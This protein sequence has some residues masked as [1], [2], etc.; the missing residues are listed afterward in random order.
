MS[1]LEIS[2]RVKR[3]YSLLKDFEDG[4]ILIPPF[5]RDYVWNNKKKTE[6][7]DS[8]NKGFPI[9]SVL[10]WQPEKIIRD[11]FYE[12][13]QTIGGY[14]LEEKNKASDAYF[15]LDGYQRLTTLFGCFISP[16]NTKLSRDETEWKHNFDIYYDLKKN[17][18][19]FNRKT[20]SSLEI[21][22]IPMYNFFDGEGYYNL[23]DVLISSTDFT[24]DEKR[25]FLDRYKQFASK[26][27]AYDIPVMELDGGSIKDAI[28]I[29]SRINSRGELIS[30]DWKV[31]A[32]SFDKDR[33]FRFGTQ[34]DEL[35]TNLER[36]NFYTSKEDRKSKRKFILDCVLNSID[37]KKAYFDIANSAEELEK[38]ASEPSFVD[39]SLNAISVI[40]KT[41]RFLYEHLLVLNNKFVSSNN[42]IIFML[43]FFKNVAEPNEYQ[44]KSLKKWF[45]LTSY[46]NYFTIYN[47]SDQREAYKV[48]QAFVKNQDTTPIYRKNSFNVKPFPDSKDFGSARY[49]SLALF[50]VNYAIRKESIIDSTAIDNSKIK[51]VTE[52]KLFKNENSIGNT[53]FIPNQN[54]EL[55]FQIR[56][57]SDLSFLLTYQFR[58][59]YEELFITDEMRDLYAKQQYKEIIQIRKSLIQQKEREFIKTLEIDYED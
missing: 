39:I 4:K 6:L 36:Y 34:I 8:L 40:E 41:I 29:F 2:T 20:K 14:F 56:H 52:F 12:K 22:Q 43:D 46:S 3:L 15:I 53:L 55:N 13:T 54:T 25:L 5:Q 17:L 58:G 9:G 48:F 57:H 28:N 31:S 10:F 59:Y 21:Y 38:L 7:L 51:G 49:T 50:M 1:N 26:I 47:L 11:K 32:L 30:D 35:F 23:S 24:S 27:S 19:E 44:I 33:N 18:F 37:N 45:W 42:Q 16:L